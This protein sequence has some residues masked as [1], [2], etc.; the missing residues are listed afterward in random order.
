MTPIESVGLTQ[1]E[2]L[3]ERPSLGAGRHAVTLEVVTACEGRFGQPALQFL[4]AGLDGAAIV[5][6]TVG[7]RLAGSNGFGELV[8]QLAGRSLVVGEKVSLAPFV[9]R[10]FVV[11]IGDAGIES[12]S[13]AVEE[14]DHD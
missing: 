10:R 11:V 14:V 1:S 5:T 8:S 3:V 6:R 4:F 9:G 7:T 2:F 12:I 13:P